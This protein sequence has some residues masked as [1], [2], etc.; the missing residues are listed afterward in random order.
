[1]TTDAREKTFE[2]DPFPELA[3]L[4]PPATAEPAS[5]S[6]VSSVPSGGAEPG[7]TDRRDSGV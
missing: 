5:D 1:M 6:P 4:V 2:D 7:L 3:Y